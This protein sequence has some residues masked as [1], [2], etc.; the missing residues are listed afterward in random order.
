MDKKKIFISSVQN[1]VAHRDY[2]TNGSVQVMLFRDRLEIWNPGSLPLGWTTQKLKDMHHSVPSNPLLAQPLYL[3]AYIERLGTGTSDM[4]SKALAAGLK[5]PEFIMEDEFRAVLFR[6]LTDATPHVN[7]LS[8]SGIISNTPQD[9]PQDTPQV[10]QLIRV[11]SGELDR[12][13]IQKLLGLKDREYVRK[14][15][16]SPSL[17]MQLIEMTIP[18]KPTSKNQKYRLTNKGL[19]LQKLLQK[20][21]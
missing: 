19:A 12:E 9:T 16:I 11:L 8:D 6:P 4:V 15:Y 5:E 18:D 2:T 14:A 21:N 13:E 1:A 3:T 10:K 7:A 20:R 17:E